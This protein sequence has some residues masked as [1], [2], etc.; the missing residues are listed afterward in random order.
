MKT[1]EEFYNA[2]ITAGSLVIDCEFCGKTYF[3][4]AEEGIYEE[5][6]LEGLREKAKKEP[7]KYIEDPNNDVIHW[8]RIN[9]KQF[10]YQCCDEEIHKFENFIWDY[11]YMIA[12][13]IKAMSIKKM[14]EAKFDVENADKLKDI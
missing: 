5:G 3:A 11:R 7:E 1:S 13:Y 6:E 10:V 4:T 12:N 2:A 14:N 9:G 8:G